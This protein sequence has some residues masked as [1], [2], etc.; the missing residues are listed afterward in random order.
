MNPYRLRGKTV[1]SFSGGRTSAYML[2]QVLDANEDRSDLLV[3]FANTGKEHPATLEFVRECAEQWDVPITWVEYRDTEPGFAVVNFDTCSRKGE[4]FEAVIRKRKYLPNPVTRFCTVELKI[5]TMHRYLKHIGW[6]NDDGEWDQMVGLR[7]DEQRRVAK[8][9]ARGA[10]TETPKEHMLMPLAD[11][12]VSVHDVGA[13][14][15]AQPFNLQLA[16]VNG[17][18]L[19][20]NCDLCFLKPMNQVYSIIATDRAKGEW[21]AAMEAGTESSGMFS[22]DGARFRKDRPSYQQMIDY[23]ELQY[24]LFAEADEGIECFCGD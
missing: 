21:W 6:T 9:R 17:R 23:A 8:I 3:L 18:T 12:G 14:W 19:E 15:L 13:F 7:A 16:T 10:S 1:L 22:G 5:R 20:G 4:P 2:R 11:A 24:D